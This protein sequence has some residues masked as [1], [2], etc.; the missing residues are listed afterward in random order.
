MTLMS[1]RV[2][3]LKKLLMDGIDSADALTSGLQLPAR[4]AVPMSM[5]LGQAEAAAEWLCEL[6]AHYKQVLDE[7]AKHLAPLSDDLQGDADI[8][9]ALAALETVE[10]G[11]LDDLYCPAAPAAH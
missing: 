9:A 10:P 7:V 2:R 8:Q 3:L 4:H 11:Y 6:A 5:H 1:A